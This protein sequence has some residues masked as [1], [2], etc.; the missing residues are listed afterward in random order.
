MKLFEVRATSERA[1]PS[2][3]IDARHAFA[4]PG[5]RCDTCGRT[6]AVTGVEYPT[7]DV[8][9]WREAMSTRHP[10]SVAEFR[11]MANHVASLTN[12]DLYLPP[13]TTLGP[14]EGTIH[15]NSTDVE[16]LTPW[17]ILL[18]GSAIS[19]LASE[20]II[21][22]TAAAGLRRKDKTLWPESIHELELRPAGGLLREEAE[23]PVC[24]V[25]GYRKL[26][27]PDH[28]VVNASTVP[29]GVQIFRVHDLPTL[30]LASEQFVNAAR[31]LRLPNLVFLPVDVR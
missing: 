31:A 7:V 6:W 28:I 25:C 30:I 2:R 26:T 15:D 11:A 9:Q 12:S 17:T 14:L 20:S 5:V 29:V 18:S 3:K 21:L 19:K 13:G 16:W 4:L 10:V 24:E 8:R 23:V 27:W 22:Q 1:V